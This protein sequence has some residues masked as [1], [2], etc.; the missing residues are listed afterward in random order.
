MA[1]I[2]P[3]ELALRQLTA[4]RV[5]KQPRKGLKPART[6]R[7]A[8][9]PVV[10]TGRGKPKPSQRSKKRQL[11]VPAKTATGLAT[12]PPSPKL[13]RPPTGF[14]RVLYQR[15]YMRLRKLHGPRSSWPPEALQQ[16]K[17][18]TCVA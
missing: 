5:G 17:G 8:P 11:E 6:A 18:T 1:K 2:G 12:S 3:R 15:T 16:L 9:K 14:D 4:K 7:L 10:R 13:G